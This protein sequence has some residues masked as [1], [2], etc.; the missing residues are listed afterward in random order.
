MKKNLLSLIGA[1]A[2]AAS[3]TVLADNP[4]A[5]QRG[6]MA[7]AIERTTE[8]RAKNP[9]SQGL[10]NAQARLAT[11]AEKHATREHGHEATEPVQRVEHGDRVDRVERV[12]RPE[13]PERVQRVERPEK[14]AR[15]ERPD[16][17]GLA[18]GPR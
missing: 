8:N 10:S 2:L 6:T 13:R 18:R 12:D 14:V 1:A 3:A 17:P 4:N 5:N 9:Q 15:V 11:N 7:R 16:P